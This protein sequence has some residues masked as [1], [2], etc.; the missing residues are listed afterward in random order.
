MA[1]AAFKLREAI[2]EYRAAF[3]NQYE[4]HQASSDQADAE[5]AKL[6]QLGTETVRFAEQFHGADT[7]A[8][9]ASCEVI[10]DE[11]ATGLHEDG[12]Y[13]EAAAVAAWASAAEVERLTAAPKQ[14]AA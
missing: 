3:R 9:L 1:T 11:L 8:L 5:I 4:W 10:T 2:S 7:K 13:R 6:I 12:L 14:E